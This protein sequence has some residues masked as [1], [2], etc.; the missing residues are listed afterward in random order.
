M[1][2]RVVA[3]E[4]AREV[5]QRYEP[6]LYV[7]VDVTADWVVGALG[8][9]RL[10][11]AFIGLVDV[12]VAQAFYPTVGDDNGCG[13]ALHSV[14]LA[15]EQ[16]PARQPAPLLIHA[17]HGAQHVG[18]TLGVNERQQLMQ[19]AVCVPEREYC[20][21]C[22]VALAYAGALHLGVLAVDVAYSTWV[23][24]RMVEC[25][26]EY[27][28]LIF[29][30]ALNAYASEV[31]VPAL[32]GIGM[33]AVEI[34]ALLFCLKVLPCVFGRYERDTN[35]HGNLLALGKVVV[36]ETVA[37]VVAR[38]LPVV[39]LIQLVCAVIGCPLGLNAA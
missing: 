23:Y 17:Y 3:R 13:V 5:P 11:H 20:I 9:C 31:A 6:V 25:R 7:W 38:N 1:R 12:E 28:L 21:A 39:V 14:C 24:E 34:L 30:A 16:F 4:V 37:Y 8:G 35:L 2:Y 32:H 19:V 33:H 26:V 22:V 15:T 18:L 27:C 10:E 36:T 29:A